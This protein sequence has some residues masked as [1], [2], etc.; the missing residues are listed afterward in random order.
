[1]A[2]A[3]NWAASKDSL[4]VPRARTMRTV[5]VPYSMETSR[6]VRMRR[7]TPDPKV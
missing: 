1:M 2:M 4:P 5:P 6:E 7:N 3:V